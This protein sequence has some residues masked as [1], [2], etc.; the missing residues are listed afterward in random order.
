MD[1]TESV[2]RASLLLVK[3]FKDCVERGGKGFHTRIFSHFL[4]P[5]TD[6]VGAGQSREVADGDPSHPEHVVPCSVLIDESARLIN[7]GVDEERIARLLSK[8][9]KVALISKEQARYMDS[10]DGLNMKNAM[11]D[12]WCFEEGDT[13]ARLR[14]AGIELLPISD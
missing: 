10:K 13:Y 14:L 3:H 4:H 7:E 8:H 2:H 1:K 6:F 5:E 12:G 11:P 9:W